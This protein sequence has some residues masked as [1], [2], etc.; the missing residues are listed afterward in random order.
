VYL[1]N[2]THKPDF[3]INNSLSLKI[4]LTV[5]TKATVDINLPIGV[6]LEGTG[7][8]RCGMAGCG[9]RDPG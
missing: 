4:K 9:A 6:E 2:L 5:L 1:I 8:I 7:E 3:Y